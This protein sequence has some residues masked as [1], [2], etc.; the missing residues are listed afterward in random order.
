M[1]KLLTSETSS[2][3]TSRTLWVSFIIFAGSVLA[4]LGV[5]VPLLEEGSTA[6]NMALAAIFAALRFITK[7][8]ITG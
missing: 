3:Y 1:G 8:P 5:N 7:K 4:A 6:M 2:W